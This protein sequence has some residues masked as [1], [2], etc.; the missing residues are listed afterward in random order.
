MD[1]IHTHTHN[2]LQGE[3]HARG[4]FFKFL[5]KIISIV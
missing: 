3:M 4:N 1:I 2:T 5:K